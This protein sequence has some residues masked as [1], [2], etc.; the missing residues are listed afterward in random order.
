MKKPVIITLSHVSSACAYCITDW[1]Y[2]I[3]P[4]YRNSTSTITFY[5]VYE[6]CHFLIKESL[7]VCSSEHRNIINKMIKI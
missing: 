2:F 5:N 1:K 6:F 3:V 7:I 4:P